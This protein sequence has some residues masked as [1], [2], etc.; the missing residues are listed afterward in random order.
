MG[1]FD[2]LMDMDFN[3]I[4]PPKDIPAGHWRSELVTVKSY[5]PD[6]S[7]ANYKRRIRLIFTPTEPEDDV[8][9]EEAQ[10]FMESDDFDGSTVGVTV[11]LHDSKRSV[12]RFMKRV[13]AIGFEGTLGQF[14][15]GEGVEGL[16]AIVDVVHEY[17][18]EGELRVDGEHFAKAE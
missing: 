11:F 2:D 18:D 10:K 17:D 16:E 1:V 14:L 4:E 6:D 8:D 3:E 13:N 15:D 9:A 12:Y 7:D 5:T